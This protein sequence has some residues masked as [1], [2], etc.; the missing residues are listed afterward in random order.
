[1]Q[2]SQVPVCHVWDDS[3][4]PAGKCLFNGP[5]SVAKYHISSRILYESLRLGSLSLPLG[6]R[7]GALAAQIDTSRRTRISLQISCTKHNV[8]PK[9]VKDDQGY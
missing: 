4:S 8:G 7:S 2:Q 3:E 6:R 9:G 1:M 5:E